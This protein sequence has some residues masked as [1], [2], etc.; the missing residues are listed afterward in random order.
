[1]PFDCFDGSGDLNQRERQ[2]QRFR[3]EQ[4][5]PVAP[6]AQKALHRSASV[7]T[8]HAVRVVTQQVSAN[9]APRHHISHRSQRLGRG[10]QLDGVDA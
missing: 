8:T 7:P 10:S 9:T 1:V 5:E 3:S 6:S 2:L 4:I